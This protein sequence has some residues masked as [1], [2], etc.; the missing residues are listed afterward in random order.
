MRD[1]LTAKTADKHALY[2]LAVQDPS[3]EIRFINRVFKKRH[4]RLPLTLRED[5]CGTAHLCSSWVSSHDGR[6]AV[7]IDLDGEVLDWGKK[8]N[9]LP[10]GASATR[11]RLLRCDVRSRIAGPFDVAVAFN[12]SYWV[13]KTRAH[14][15]AY[16]SS[17]Y[18]SLRRGG[19]FYLDCHG[20]LTGQE[21]L[22]ERRR[23]PGFTFIWQQGHLNPI[24]HAVTNHIHF[25]FP[26]KSILKRAFSYQWRFWS[27]PEIRDLLDEAGFRQSTVY[28]EGPGRDGRGDGRFK[29]AKVVANETAWIAYVV[30]ER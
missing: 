26:D 14:M 5:F 6:T 25:S 20:G 1:E 18:R 27:L 22:I 15:L 30:A 13:F 2:Q 16:F 12:S 8:H 9:L 10:L 3:A 7:G 29:P 19:L 24:D 23:V 4:A 17:V 21:P 28:W 11:V